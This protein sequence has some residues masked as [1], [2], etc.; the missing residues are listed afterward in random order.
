[1]KKGYKATYNFKCMDLTYEVGKEY[2]I[3]DKKLC[4]HGFHYCEVLDDTLE[5]YE[6]NEDLVLL[7]IEDLDKDSVKGSGKVVSDHIKIL[8]VVPHNELDRCQFDDNG[9]MISN[10]EWT[11]TYNKDGKVLECI[12]EDD[13]EEI[14][15]YDTKGNTIRYET[16]DPK[17]HFKH[18]EEYTYDDR[19]NLLTLLTDKGFFSEKMY[20]ENNNVIYHK[21]STGF[22][23]KKTY[24]QNNNVLTYVEYKDGEEVYFNKKTYNEHGKILTYKDGSLS[25]EYTY[26]DDGEKTSYK[27]SE[28]NNWERTYTEKDGLKCVKHIGS[29]GLEWTK[30]YDENGNML[31]SSFPDSSITHKYDKHNNCISYSRNGFIY[32]E[33]SYDDKGNCVKYRSYNSQKELEKSWD[34]TII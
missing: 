2:K 19:G 11:K 6:Y 18:V 20:D 15:T 12:F 4:S 25:F 10:G 22:E 1:M 34:I 33:K 7:E 29:N 21:D 30:V 24:D 14:Y 26:N 3:T 28:G 16:Y 32:L 31:E 8:R 23:Y 27:S 17:S 13:Y 5:F 9:N